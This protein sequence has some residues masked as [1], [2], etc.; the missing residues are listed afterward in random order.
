MEESIL[1][2]F[3]LSKD[4]MLNVSLERG[5]D[6]IIFDTKVLLSIPLLPLLHVGDLLLENLVFTA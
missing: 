6:Q 5:F 4:E 1:E 2:V 3:F